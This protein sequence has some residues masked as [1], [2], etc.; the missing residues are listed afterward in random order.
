M[1][2]RERMDWLQDRFERAL[3]LPSGERQAFVDRECRKDPEAR[4]RLTALLAADRDSFLLDRPLLERSIGPYRLERELGRG[5]MGTVYLA[6]GEERVALKVL[7][8]HLAVHPGFSERFLREA[9]AGRRVNHPNVVRTLDGAVVDTDGK[10]LLYLVMEYVEGRT[11]RQLLEELG[12]V[13][14]ALL[15]EIAVQAAAGLAAIH[16]AGIV[17]RDLKPGNILI[18]DDH[19]VRIM[20]LGV[21]RDVEGSLDLTGAGQFVGSLPYAAPEQFGDAEVG[22]AADLYALGV[23]LYELATG[24]NPFR[25][26]Q[27][28]AVMKAHLETVP[29]PVEDASPFFARLIATLLAKDPPQRFE[30][31]ERLHRLLEEG[32]ESSWWGSQEVF[33]SRHPCIPVQRQ[34]KLYGRDTELGALR[35]VWEQARNGEGRLLLLEGE[36]GI[37]KTRL[38][39]AFLGEIDAGTVLYGSY[40]PSG[41]MGGLSDSLLDHFGSRALD[42]SLRPHL[43]QTPRLVSPFAAVVRHEGAESLTVEALHTVFCHLMRGLAS[44]RPL[45]W[46]V[47][48]LHFAGLDARK[49][50]LSMARALPGHRV[51]LVASTRPGIPEDELAEWTRLEQVQRLGLGRLSPREVIQL[52]RDAFRSERLAEKLGGKIA[53]KSDGIP[54]FVFE[55]IRGLQEGQFIEKLPDGTWVESKVIEEIEVPSAVKDLISARLRDLTAD[56]RNLLDV[57]SVLG[58]EFDPSLVAAVLKRERV[59]VLQDLAR[60]Q[61]SSGVVQAAGRDYRFD[62]H[63]IQEVVYAELFDGLK[64][65]YHRLVADAYQRRLEEEPSGEDA[66]FLASHYLLGCRPEEGRSC[67]FPALACLEESYR[68]EEAIELA[69][70]ALSASA[71][72]TSEERVEVLLKKATRHHLCGD[73]K[74]EREALDEALDLAEASEQAKPR[75]K[76]RYS[77]GTH[78]S[79]LGSNFDAAKH[80][81]EQG[82]DLAR[83]AGDKG[84]EARISASLGGVLLSQGSY[85]EARLNQERSLAL[86]REI[87][88]RKSEA[89]ALGNL[90]NICYCVGRY[91]EARAHMESCSTLARQAGDPI[92]EAGAAGNLAVVLSAQGLYDE[93]RAQCERGLV[94][95]R[96]IGHRD[97]EAS[98]AGNLGI[99]FSGLGRYAEARTHYERSLALAREI[100]NR[101]C[102][103]ISLL[104]LGFL[105]TELGLVEIARDSLNEALRVLREIGARRPEGYALQGLG[106][107]AE[108]R[109]DVETARKLYEES[110]ALRKEISYMSGVANMLVAL[111]RLAVQQGDESAGIAYFDEALAVAEGLQSPDMILVATM[112]RASLPGGDRDAAVA[113][114][115]NLDLRAHHT[116]RVYVHYRIWEL[117]EDRAHLDEA[118][119]LLDL[120]VEH[121]PEDCRISMIENVPLHRDI[122]RAWEEQAG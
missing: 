6:E 26:D 51:L 3:A 45:I 122:V 27:P 94:L 21:A 24:A 120:A 46:V 17:H 9:E 83:S 66:V 71:L 36:A 116:W 84:I 79:T 44:D 103:G 18:T 108:H 114:L 118:K 96:E 74:L 32:E 14:E 90:G 50:L 25:H 2:S 23:V 82:R 33:E 104:N 37:G 88:D 105:Q 42:E 75:A 109:G 81:L 4:D 99:L 30:S 77:L 115:S 57:G 19:R 72:L 31:A 56:E 35:Q 5:G 112:E 121:A 13:P 73:S 113:A 100:G 86:A 47:E 54:F 11:L 68:N 110:L 10:T 1:T 106:F 65:E 97:G 12:S 107:L 49:I 80:C 95:A 102:E 78:L 69:N 59:T 8:P 85:E 63:Q 29:R 111:G 34:T 93:A 67:V 60:V 62:H 70:R 101:E 39:D 89:R 20:D 38:L 41:G 76:V 7:H 28:Q 87:G 55:M 43:D 52:L 119:R 98:A 48:D 53:Y 40:P 58:F 15:R 91:D 117:T 16:E 92:D 64:E 22:P 61:R